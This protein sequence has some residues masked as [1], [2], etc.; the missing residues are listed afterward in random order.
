MSNTVGWNR[1]VIKGRDW[2]S[3]LP[4]DC[5]NIKSITVSASLPFIDT[6]EIC[7]C[8]NLTKVVVKSH[9]PNASLILRSENS[10]SA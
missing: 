5:D 8:P 7:D 9:S 6:I 2:S 3:E 4:I 1:L 10:P